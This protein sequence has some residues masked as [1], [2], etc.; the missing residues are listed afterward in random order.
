LVE[1]LV[2]IAII[3]ILAALLM[4]TLAQGKRRAQQ[5]QC[6]GNMHQLGLALLGYVGD[7]HCY[8]PVPGWVRALEREGL[9]ISKPGT[10]F[11]EEGV[12]H[13]PSAR[14]LARN[15]RRDRR[16]YSY[17]YNNW[18]VQD[19]STLRV[20]D[21]ANKLGLRY[22]TNGL[23]LPESEVVV[24]SAMM[25]V[26]DSLGTGS[27]FL[28]VPLS[29]MRSWGNPSWSDMR[30]PGNPFER[31]QGK[32]NVLFCDGHVES[33]T[34]GFLFVDTSDNALVRWNRDHLPHRDLLQP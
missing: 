14:V 28:R 29:D 24:P 1:L 9:G 34:L 13:C 21:I 5:I 30:N 20:V 23:P 27:V 15:A 19:G 4:P 6:A 25:A 16:Q 2:T 8:P 33:P 22:D 10:N 7:N 3:G 31:H 17:G 32:V 12:W 26:G 18:G 11:L